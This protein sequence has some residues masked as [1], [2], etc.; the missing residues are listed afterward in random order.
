MSEKEEDND[1]VNW[2]PIGWTYKENMLRQIDE[3]NEMK[4]PIR[5]VRLKNEDG[6]EKMAILKRVELK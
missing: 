4:I 2:E 3:C 6:S 5:I 1:W